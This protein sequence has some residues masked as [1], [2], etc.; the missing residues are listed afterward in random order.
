MKSKIKTIP[1]S[2]F[3]IG[4]I[5]FHFLKLNTITKKVRYLIEIM[6][7]MNFDEEELI[8]ESKY[9]I[10]YSKFFDL[11]LSNLKEKNSNS[12]DIKLDIRFDDLGHLDEKEKKILFW[13]LQFSILVENALLLF[14]CFLNQGRN[15][16]KLITTFTYL[17]ENNLDNPGELQKSYKK[18]LLSKEIKKIDKN[19]QINLIGF[20]QLENQY[21]LKKNTSQKKKKINNKNEDSTDK[22]EL[23]FPEKK[24]NTKKIIST[25]NLEQKDSNKKIYNMNK[26]EAKEVKSKYVSEENIQFFSGKNFQD[27]QN[28]NE[29]KNIIEISLEKV[30]KSSNENKKNGS[31]KSN[32]GKISQISK[33]EKNESF[34]NSQKHNNENAYLP[35][36]PEK[37]P[38][39]NSSYENIN[40]LLKKA[41]SGIK[42]SS[43][44]AG[45]KAKYSNIYKS[46]KD[47]ADYIRRLNID[48]FTF[49][50][51]SNPFNFSKI[52]NALEKI[53]NLFSNEDNMVDSNYG[54]FLKEQQILFY[55]SD[56][57]EKSKQEKMYNSSYLKQLDNDYA[58]QKDKIGYFVNKGMGFEKNWEYFFDF[59]FQLP[60]L[61]N[62]F[63]PARIKMNN[64]DNM[65]NFNLKSNK[66]EIIFKN[67]VDNVFNSFIETDISRINCE[68][69]D[70]EPN[71]FFKPYIN[72]FPIHVH[73]K[74]EA[75]EWIAEIINKK[76]FKVYA[77]SIIL[78]E[79]KNSILEKVLNIDDN[80][81]INKKDIQRSLYFVIFKLIK[82]IEYYYEFVKYEYLTNSKQINS[83]KFQLFL[84]YDNKPITQMNE[85]IRT[86]LNNIIKK[87]HIKY[88][89]FFQM[90]YSIPAISNFNINILSNKIKFLSN[91]IDQL[92]DRLNALEKEK[93][94]NDRS[95][96]EKK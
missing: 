10:F 53:R 23:K 56:E 71:I 2:D 57:E 21:N 46:N 30:G 39:K 73:K 41:L 36:L 45:Q 3:K 91:E 54:F 75:N 9:E 35:E 94:N 17:D 20:E 87:N 15:E 55:T 22:S 29:N 92:K 68:D 74:K 65:D 47:I 70:I 96:N 90:V 18:Q 59:H 63:F 27:N 69:Y 11:V 28:L 38:L 78:A 42:V 52:N 60:K 26:K 84:I 31:G 4:I 13:Y 49:N 16:N 5:F 33:L 50:F 12:Q 48:N 61:P 19:S 66:D 67:Y 64:G 1:V 77:N 89:F 82:K 24:T 40:N 58:F 7:V 8:F 88:E 32:K 43:Y 79:I 86:C 85:H 80:D 14:F 6:K 25:L 81:L 62:L 44:F 51:L 83:Y 76:E 93:S 95:N 34:D 72:E 37:T